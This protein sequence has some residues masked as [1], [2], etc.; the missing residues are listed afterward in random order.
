MDRTAQNRFDP[1][2]KC[3]KINGCRSYPISF[4]RRRSVSSFGSF[5]WAASPMVRFSFQ[6]S[7]LRSRNSSREILQGACDLL[8]R[9]FAT[10]L[11]TAR[12]PLVTSTRWEAGASRP[13]NYVL[14]FAYRIFVY[15]VSR[16]RQHWPKNV[17]GQPNGRNHVDLLFCVSP[18]HVDDVMNY[19]MN[20]FY[21]DLLNNRSY[22]E[23]CTGVHVFS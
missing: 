18:K 23:Y 16:N 3:S 10:P 2:I 8:D 4:S 14:F 7:I 19:A 9:R 22:S 1:T 12:C 15:C 5:S 6:K 13:T 21:R 11:Q 20:V 17:S